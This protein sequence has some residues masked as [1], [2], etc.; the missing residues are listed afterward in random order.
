VDDAAN[1]AGHAVQEAGAAVAQGVST[2]A[3]KA[4]A[5]AGEAADAT[6]SA[7]AAVGQGA[8]ST[9]EKAKAAGANALAGAGEL[10][11]K[12]ADAVVTGAEKVTGKDLNKDGKI[13]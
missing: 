2:A 3:D 4:K 12:A 9:L 11:G 13:G 8:Q 10:A 1:K 6:V 7:G 5:L